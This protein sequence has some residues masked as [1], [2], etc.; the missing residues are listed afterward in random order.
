MSKFQAKIT[1][2]GDKVKIKLENDIGPIKLDPYYCKIKAMVGNPTQLQTVEHIPGKSEDMHIFFLNEEN[3]KIVGSIY[4]IKY[5]PLPNPAGMLE[6][7]LH[8]NFKS[9]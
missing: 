9:T 2:N 6:I 7:P 8:L 4:S 3:G 5:R 1:N